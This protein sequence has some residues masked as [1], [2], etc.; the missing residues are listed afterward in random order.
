MWLTKM[1][2]LLMSVCSG[3]VCTPAYVAHL[4]SEAECH[5]TLS[6]LTEVMEAHVG[7]GPEIEIAYDCMPVT[8]PREA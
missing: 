3:D 1:W 5:R 7:D 4:T 2:V 6:A 8:P